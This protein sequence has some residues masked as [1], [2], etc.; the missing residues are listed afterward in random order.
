MKKRFF[1]LAFLMSFYSFSQVTLTSPLVATK[2]V[3]QSDSSFKYRL[4]LSNN[5]SRG[6]LYTY[7]STDQTLSLNDIQINSSRIYGSYFNNVPYK[8]YT[9]YSTG[10]IPK[11]KF[12]IICK[13]DVT[14]QNAST[15]NFDSF[16][17]NFASPTP[18]CFNLTD[19]S[20]N[21]DPITGKPDLRVQT[22]NVAIVSECSS[23]SIFLG[24]LGSNRY[25]VSREGGILSLNQIIVDNIGTAPASAS[26][27][28]FY[29]ST[30]T[31]LDSSDYKF[32]SNSI[33]VSSISAGQ[34][35]GVSKSIFGSD[36]SYN[37]AYGNYNILM[38]VDGDNQLTEL[39]ENNNVTV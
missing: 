9:V 10:S 1:I 17:Q 16:I 5:F 38:K 25:I 13:T 39:N 34:Y 26:M 32:N 7:L 18:Y 11:G 28:N 4:G 8:E 22:S 23:C 31:S 2:L 30:D 3:S 20:Q 21:C 27:I 37:Q 12:Y 33:N 15:G 29:L 14:I 19:N 35:V 36:F 6:Y 24:S